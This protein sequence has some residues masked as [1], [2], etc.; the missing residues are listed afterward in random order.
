MPP[1]RLPSGAPVPVGVA[2]TSSR[3]NPGGTESMICQRSTLPV[4]PPTLTKVGGAG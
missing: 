1:T 4:K 3:M 2:P